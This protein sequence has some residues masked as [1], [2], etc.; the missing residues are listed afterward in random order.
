[1][2]LETIAIANADGSDYLIINRSDYN[3][4]QHQL[5]H[6]PEP[7]R[8]PPDDEP[9]AIEERAVVLADTHTV[10]ELKAIAKGLEITGYST[11][12]QAELAA[13]IARAGG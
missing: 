2:K 3:P 1:M 8:K 9:T 13:A 10:P 4:K 12:K 7:G 5:W 6:E 11:M